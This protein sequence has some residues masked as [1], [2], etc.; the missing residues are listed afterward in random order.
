ME[1]PT[2]QQHIRGER[3]FCPSIPFGRIVAAHEKQP[4]EDDAMFRRILVAFKFSTA[5]S[6]ALEIG[7]RLAGE[8]NAA[9]H[10]FHALDYNLSRLEKSDPAMSEMKALVQKRLNDEVALQVGDLSHAQLICQ[11]DDPAMGIC[12]AATEL[13]A[14]LIILGAH[15]TQSKINLG[16][17]DYIAMTVLEKAPCPVMMVPYR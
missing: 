13:G 1:I 3:S 6:L 12:K 2:Q 15:H 7:T 5:G 11:P 17:L 16:R 10:I 9:L 14:D 4:K 8:Q